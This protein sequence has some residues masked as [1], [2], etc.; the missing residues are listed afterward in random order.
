MAILNHRGA[1][2]H[3]RS[4]AILRAVVG[5]AGIALPAACGPEPEPGQFVFETDKDKQACGNGK[6]EREAGETSTTC[7]SDCCK[8]GDGE[9]DKPNCETAGC[10]ETAQTCPTD[11]LPCGDN[12]CEAGESPKTCFRDC[13][14]SCGDGKCL[15]GAC[16]ENNKADPATHCPQDCVTPCGNAICDP[17]ENPQNCPEDCKKKGCGNFVCDFPDDTPQSCPGDCLAP[18]GDGTCATGE[19]Y[20]NCPVDCGY[21]GDDVCS[22]FVKETKATCPADCK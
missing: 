22:S 5:L 10:G 8:C 13:C 20:T 19:N 1:P 17:G 11:C 16:G 2:P 18:C 4:M 3:H 21:C 15:G 14:G 12:K 6:C 7:P 9:V